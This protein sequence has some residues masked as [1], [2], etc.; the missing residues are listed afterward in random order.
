MRKIVAGLFVS[1]D[2]VVESPEKWTFPYFSEDVAQELGSLMARSDLLLL[3]RRT[4]EEFA[5]Y[6]PTRSA[7]EDPAAAYLNS[8]RKLVVSTKLTSAEWENS[9]VIDGDLPSALAELRDQPGRDIQITGSITLVRSLLRDQLLDELRLLLYPTVVGSGG[10]LF[11][12]STGPVSLEL[13][14]SRTLTNGVLSLVYEP[15]RS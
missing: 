13:V 10:R 6:W 2:G 3:G 1:L 5:A 7:E 9:S 14:G 4:Y 8:V 11:D 15:A 12:G